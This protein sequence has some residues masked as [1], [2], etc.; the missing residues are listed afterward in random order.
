MSPLSLVT[1]DGIPLEALE[2]NGV[3][4]GRVVATNGVAAS[5]GVHHPPAPPAPPEPETLRNWSWIIGEQRPAARFAP[6]ATHA[7][8]GIV[9]PARGFA[10]WRLQPEWIDQTARS[11]G[12]RWQNCALI[13]RL[14]DVSYIDFNG[15]N[16][17][18][19]VDITLPN[20]CGQMLFHLA[21]PG[22]VQL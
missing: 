15:F 8:I 2:G 21:R 14:Y 11:R 6:T 13:L 9:N 18:A 17:H 20:I 16:A 22:T 3:A 10:H 4:P 19:I 5:N 7:G 12:H 1:V